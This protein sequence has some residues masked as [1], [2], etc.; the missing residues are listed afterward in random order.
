M[1]WLDDASPEALKEALLSIARSRGLK[2]EQVRAYV[3]G[4]PDDRTIECA[5]LVHN[6]FCTDKKDAETEMCAFELEALTGKDESWLMEDH[7]KWLHRTKE[8]LNK[9]N[10]NPYDLTHML[11]DAFHAAGQFTVAF[12][13]LDMLAA[14]IIHMKGMEKIDLI[15]NIITPSPESEDRR[16]HMFNPDHV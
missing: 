13:D 15:L 8:L 1:K 4:L 2:D 10:T 7:K 11:R 3:E 14:I 16:S 12:D 9:L 5:E 6:I